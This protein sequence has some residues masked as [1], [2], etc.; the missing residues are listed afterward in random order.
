LITHNTDN[1]IPNNFSFLLEDA[2][3]IAWFTVNPDIVHPK[4]IPIPLGLVHKLAPSGC[5]NTSVFDELNSRSDLLNKKNLL[6]MNFLI[7]T[8]RL[9]RQ[10]VW[11]HFYY[12][13]FCTKSNSKNFREYIKDLTDSIFVLSPP[14]AGRDCHNT[15]EALL[16]GCIPIIKSF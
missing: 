12:K 15:Y 1:Y 8:N 5:G 10:P 9:E 2:K 11:D 13:S 14:G 3:L 7:S 4:I 16:A 6:Y